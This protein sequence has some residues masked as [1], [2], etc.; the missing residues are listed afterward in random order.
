[1]ACNADQVMQLEKPNIIKTF[2]RWVSKFICHAR[3]LLHIKTS[4]TILLLGRSNQVRCCGYEC[5]G[6]K[7][8]LGLLDP[9]LPSTRETI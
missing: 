2:L 8:F 5:V 1:M 7:N 4:P 9:V 6:S 3:I